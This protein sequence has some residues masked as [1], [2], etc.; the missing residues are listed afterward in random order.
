[1]RYSS[2]SNIVL[3]LIRCELQNTLEYKLFII[4]FFFLRKKYL[5]GLVG[6]ALEALFA[7]PI[8][9]Y[10]SI[11]NVKITKLILQQTQDIIKSLAPCSQNNPKQLFIF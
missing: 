6:L 7:R 9:C 5:Y 8:Q 2:K 11:N 10:T 4:Q 3:K 1:M